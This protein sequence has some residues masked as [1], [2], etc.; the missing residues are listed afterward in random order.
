MDRGM[1]RLDVCC[2]WEMR[3]RGYVRATK[4][5]VVCRNGKSGGYL[6]NWGSV[7]V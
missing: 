4:T 2:E 6:R 5:K 1:M 7:E 3:G